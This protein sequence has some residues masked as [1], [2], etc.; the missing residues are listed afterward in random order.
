MCASFHARERTQ[1]LLLPPP[2]LM[3]QSE[4]YIFNYICLTFHNERSKKK[5]QLQ[6]LL[7]PPPRV[8]RYFEKISWETKLIIII[9]ISLSKLYLKYAYYEK[10]REKK[11]E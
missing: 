7:P 9:K 2:S 1:L 11:N 4:L 5:N 10:K 6:L 8:L 3:L